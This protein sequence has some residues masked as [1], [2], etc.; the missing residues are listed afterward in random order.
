MDGDAYYTG[1]ISA[2][3]TITYEDVV[4]ID[5][6]GIITGRSDLNILGNARIVGVL[7]AGESSITIDGDN[8]QIIVGGEDKV[9]ITASQVTIGTGVTISSSASG[10]NS[11]PNV[12]YV[13]KDGQDTNNGTSIDNA[14]LTISGAVG[15]AQSGTTIKVLSGKY[16]EANP[17][18]VPAFVSIVGDDQRTVEVSG[19]TVSYTHLT[20]PPIYSV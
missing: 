16:A 8:N 19:L 1:N 11:A 18:E 6:L 4:N 15:V 12:F 13:A 2:A 7:T 10:I 3:G 9:T 14:F 17:I 5:S 20:L